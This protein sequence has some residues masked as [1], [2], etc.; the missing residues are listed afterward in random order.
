MY[1]VYLYMGEIIVIE[2]VQEKAPSKCGPKDPPPGKSGT[3][4]AHS[5]S[6]EGEHPAK[7]LLGTRLNCRRM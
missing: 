6:H 1:I 7:I 3:D 4:R 5:G 2:L